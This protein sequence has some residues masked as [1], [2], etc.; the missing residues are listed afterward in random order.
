[1]INDKSAISTLENGYPNG[2]T[3]GTDFKDSNG[4]LSK[5]HEF[6]AKKAKKIRLNL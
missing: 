5:R 3:D 6:Q 4:F 1:M 2:K